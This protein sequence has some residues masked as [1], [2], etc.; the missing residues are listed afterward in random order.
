MP[1][2]ISSPCPSCGAPFFPA[3]LAIHVRTCADK[4]ARTR[5]EC[6]FCRGFFPLEELAAH[7]ESCAL[8]PL[9]D[10]SRVFLPQPPLRARVAAAGAAAPPPPPPP[11]GARGGCP[12]CGRLFAA[13]RLHVHAN[14]CR[15]AH[16]A[17][18]VFDSAAQRAVRSAADA[19]GLGGSPG[20]GDGT[21]GPPP[22]LRA[23]RG[24]AAGTGAKPPP[25]AQ[26]SVSAAGCDDI[27]PREGTPGQVQPE[28]VA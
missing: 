19:R 9:R 23:R 2:P 5:H 21:F 12:L 14:A 8:R 27:A 22:P 26:P 3:G 18:R 17:R 24:A 6:A 25:P 7:A 28:A 13:E 10:D 16:R 20:P 11:G 4:A 1:R 15:R